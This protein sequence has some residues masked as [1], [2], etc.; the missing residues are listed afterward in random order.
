MMKDKE[1]E[2]F[3][4]TVYGLMRVPKKNIGKPRKYANKKPPK[5]KKSVV[6]GRKKIKR[7]KSKK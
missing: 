3:G 2:E 6:R 7:K 1:E 5:K 4:A